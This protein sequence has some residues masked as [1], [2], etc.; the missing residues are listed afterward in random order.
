MTPKQKLNKVYN[1][2]GSAATYDLA[3]TMNLPYSFCKPCDA[4]TPTVG[5]RHPECAICGTP[6]TKPAQ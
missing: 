6:K 4:Q 2:Q 5:T 3:N 1:E